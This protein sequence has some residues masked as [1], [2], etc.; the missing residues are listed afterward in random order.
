MNTVP[1]A[2]GPAVQLLPQDWDAC[3]LGQNPS[4]AG[5]RGLPLCL[6]RMNGHAPGM[7]R[8]TRKST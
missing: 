3:P 4:V 2:N 7:Q 5:E 8:A 6:L 1:W